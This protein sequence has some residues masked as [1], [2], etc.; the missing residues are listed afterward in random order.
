MIPIIVPFYD[1]DMCIL[2]V[3]MISMPRKEGLKHFDSIQGLT[4]HLGGERMN[5]ITNDEY[6]CFQK[7]KV[8]SDYLLLRKWISM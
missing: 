3:K 4:F 2:N 6:F 8:V 1:E 5:F 7:T